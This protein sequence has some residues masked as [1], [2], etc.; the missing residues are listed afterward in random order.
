MKRLILTCLLLSVFFI[1]GS[2]SGN[3][4]SNAD[5]CFEW[6][7]DP[8]Q[9]SF[10]IIYN[11]TGLPNPSWT[12]TNNLFV[13]NQYNY[14]KWKTVWLEITFITAPTSDPLIQLNASPESCNL[15]KA[16]W[17]IDKQGNDWTWCWTINPQPSNETLI[18]P[19]SSYYYLNGNVES[20]EVGTRCIPEPA[21][22][23]M[24]VIGGFVLR[25]R[26][27]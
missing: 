19:D 16:F 18:F 15:G 21:T 11:K 9:G 8:C 5:Y 12:S 14:Y 22:I 3:I 24:L 10:T 2:A 17:G 23:G 27:R 1:S 6:M 26:K 7:G 25:R 13:N 4:P 20:I